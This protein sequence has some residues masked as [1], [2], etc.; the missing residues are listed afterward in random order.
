MRI[1]ALTLLLVIG[2]VKAANSK[3]DGYYIGD[4]KVILYGNG[5]KSCEEGLT[6]LSVASDIILRSKQEW[7]DF[8]DK[9]PFFVLGLADSTCAKC[10][11]SEPILNQLQNFVKDKAVMSYP[12]VN[13]KKK[14]VVRKEIKI[15]RIDT[16]DDAFLEQMRARGIG[17]PKG[18]STIAIIKNGQMHKYDGMFSEINMLLNQMQRIA[19]PTVQ[20]DSEE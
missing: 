5:V 9:N 12:E 11:D 7:D 20:L 18:G 2:V 15:V 6:T 10:C 13:K 3:R 17:F 1:V 4:D 14:K 19:S 16:S 8:L